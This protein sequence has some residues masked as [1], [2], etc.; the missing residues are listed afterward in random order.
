MK[1]KKQQIMKLARI[2]L[3]I[4]LTGAAMHVLCGQQLPLPGVVRV[5][6]HLWNPAFTGQSGPWGAH[7]TYAQQWIGFDGAPV[8]AIVGGHKHLD[9][10]RMA[11]GANMMYDVTGPV[12]FAGLAIAY[13]YQ[14]NPN[15][16]TDQDRLAFGILGTLG[17]R[18]YDPTTA[19]VNDVQDP[20]LSGE[21]VGSFD[22]NAGV[23][24]LYRTVP[25]N[26]LYKS[27]FYAGLGASKLIPN[28]LSF[29]ETSYGNRIHANAVA[30]WR[31]ARDLYLDHIFWLNY[32]DAD[33]FNVSYQFR[34]ENPDVFW[35]GLL[36]NSN[37]TFGIESGMILDG[38]WLQAE[39]FRIGAMA[40]YSL[41][42]FGTYQGFNLGINFELVKEF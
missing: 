23:G 17:M 6:D 3:A 21:A 26:R 11:V 24:I 13:K 15:L 33:L 31:T 5:T 19:R 32:A 20:L 35:A 18:R 39:Q 27:H 9:G 2:I 7:A 29:G 4:C 38:S 12:S 10:D 8:T 16:F 34:L 42:K 37:L 14:I 22:V 25:D 41:G 30:G 1:S 40:S 36:M 28:K